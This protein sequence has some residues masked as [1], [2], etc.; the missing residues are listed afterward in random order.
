M[1]SSNSAVEVQSSA[2]EAFLPRRT[3]HG[4]GTPTLLPDTLKDRKTDRS[5]H[6]EV[7]WFTLSH[8]YTEQ[9]SHDLLLVLLCLF[10]KGEF[11]SHSFF[12]AFASSSA[13]LHNFLLFTISHA[14]ILQLLLFFI[15]L[16][17]TKSYDYLQLLTFRH[18][19]I[20]GPLVCH[21]FCQRNPCW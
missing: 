4:I 1:S 7:A 19:T 2:R 11:L 21:M 18:Q 6:S 20:L 9:N 12:F 17:S 5:S 3:P 16:P 14:K 15:L 13:I 10:L 8:S